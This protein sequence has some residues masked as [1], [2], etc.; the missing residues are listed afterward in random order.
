MPVTGSN[1]RDTAGLASIYAGRLRDCQPFFRAERWESDNSSVRSLS[2]L[3]SF[4][5]AATLR[6][7]GLYIG[8]TASLTDLSLFITIS[9]ICGAFLVGDAIFLGEFKAIAH[10]GPFRQA[11]LRGVDADQRFHEGSINPTPSGSSTQL[12]KIALSTALVRDENGEMTS[13]VGAF[14]VIE[15]DHGRGRT[16]GEV[17]EAVVEELAERLRMVLHVKDDDNDNDDEREE[18]V[19]G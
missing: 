17:V 16:G 9:L 14:P 7:A 10:G 6:V 18:R 13:I 1:Q 12:R 15:N 2:F 11:L 3:R 19:V 8:D 4:L 5:F